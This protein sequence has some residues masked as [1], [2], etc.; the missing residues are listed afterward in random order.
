MNAVTNLPNLIPGG[1]KLGALK[2]DLTNQLGQLPNI[3][4][5]TS[6]GGAQITDL[7]SKLG[8]ISQMPDL[9]GL[10]LGGATSG[11]LGQLDKLSSF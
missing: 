6:L 4:Q 2:G 10:D 11:G 5:I 8:G 3:D 9:T 7:K 1:E